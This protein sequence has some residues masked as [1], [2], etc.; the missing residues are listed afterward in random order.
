MYPTQ[1]APHSNANG[2]RLCGARTFYGS[3]ARQERPVYE[4]RSRN[5]DWR[6]GWSMGKELQ[7]IS[8]GMLPQQVN[9]LC[10]ACPSESKPQD[11]HD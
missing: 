5:Q 3:L 1:Q 6:M 10:Q 11:P 9:T 7:P 4:G 8:A 2:Q